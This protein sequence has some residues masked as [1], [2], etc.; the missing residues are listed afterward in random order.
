M[1]S[2]LLGGSLVPFRELPQALQKIGRWTMIR[3]GNYGIESIFNS[4]GIWE[5]LRPSLFL[6]AVGTL[7]MGLG[8]IV[9]RKRFESGKVA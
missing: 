8:T 1:T 7:L 9:M 5:V 6:I 4:R 2:A 3:M